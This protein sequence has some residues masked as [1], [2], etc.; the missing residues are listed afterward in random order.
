MVP[1]G[2]RRIPSEAAGLPHSFLTA[3]GLD[4]PFLYFEAS[5]R[6]LKGEEAGT[7]TTLLRAGDEEV[8]SRAR[9]PSVVWPT[10]CVG[11][12]VYGEAG[13]VSVNSS[14]SSYT[15]CPGVPLKPSARLVGGDDEKRVILPPKDRKT[16]PRQ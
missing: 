1:A 12:V 11:C 4:V 3:S 14:R 16:L 6:A 7:S 13:M 10:S 9:G 5:D 8:R 15:A 2:A